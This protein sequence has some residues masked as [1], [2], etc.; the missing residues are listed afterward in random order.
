MHN[1]SLHSAL[2][3]LQVLCHLQK[4]LRSRDCVHGR[5]SE[6]SPHTFFTCWDALFLKNVIKPQVN[7]LIKIEQL[8]PKS[9]EHHPFEYLTLNN[10]L[11]RIVPLN[12][13]LCFSS[14]LTLCAQEIM[15]WFPA[16]EEKLELINPDIQQWFSRLTGDTQDK[17]QRNRRGGGST[18]L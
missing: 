7:F 15:V 17:K 9:K 11:L 4:G 13:G 5:R 1:G 2:V 14:V 12:Q 18:F 6:P 10:I 8:C 3:Y 16:L